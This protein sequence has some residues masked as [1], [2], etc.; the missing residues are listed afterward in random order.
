M[1]NSFS[2]GLHQEQVGWVSS[3]CSFS[4]ALGEGEHPSPYLSPRSL[5]PHHLLT[6]CP[7]TFLLSSVLIFRRV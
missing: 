1:R 5:V 4:Q 6:G 2:E 3:F 7:H